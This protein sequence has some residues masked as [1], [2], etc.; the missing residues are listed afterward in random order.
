M[1]SIYASKIGPLS[2]EEEF[3]PSDHPIIDAMLTFQNE[4]T[5]GGNDVLVV[6][7]F[8]GVKDLD[9]SQGNHWD[10]EYIGEA[11]MDPDFDLSPEES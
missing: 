7:M 2:S 1:A 5:G 9:R 11:E 4:F 8:W 6:N 3:L 10:T